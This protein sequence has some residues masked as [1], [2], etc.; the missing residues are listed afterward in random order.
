[1]YTM[2]RPKSG[3]DRYDT[4]GSCS[5]SARPPVAPGAQLP[6]SRYLWRRIGFF[7]LTA[8]FFSAGA[9]TMFR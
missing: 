8:L 4:P 2:R 7:L 1:M 6:P 9:A 5:D 3:V